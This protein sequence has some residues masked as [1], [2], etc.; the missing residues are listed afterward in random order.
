MRLLTDD[1]TMDNALFG[2]TS[3]ESLFDH[4]PDD[5]TGDVSGSEI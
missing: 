3:A 2:Q 4:P 1:L 5:L